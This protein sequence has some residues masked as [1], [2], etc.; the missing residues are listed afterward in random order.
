[1]NQYIQQVAQPY[2]FPESTCLEGATAIRGS[3]KVGLCS[4][5]LLLLGQKVQTEGL[6]GQRQ[7]ANHHVL[8]IDHSLP[9]LQQ[10]V[11]PNFHS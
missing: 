1:M 6:T 8:T 4:T 10:Q 11:L 5:D 2:C 9:A 7:S 3:H